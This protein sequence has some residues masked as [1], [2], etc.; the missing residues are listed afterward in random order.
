M[1]YRVIFTIAFLA[2]SGLDIKFPAIKDQTARILV[3]AA[4]VIVIML[5]ANWLW[6]MAVNHTIRQLAKTN[7]ALDLI[8]R[9][10]ETPSGP[11]ETPEPY[12]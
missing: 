1:R 5:V 6:A 4:A 12:R 9:E 8:L 2:I 3:Q 10:C 11:Q 7:A